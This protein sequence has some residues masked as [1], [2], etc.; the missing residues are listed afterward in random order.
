VFLTSPRKIVM[1][2]SGDTVTG[3]VTIY[4]LNKLLEGCCRVYGLKNSL[5]FSNIFVDVY[6]KKIRN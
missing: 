2:M 5:P 6:L 4:Y 1:S 3:Q